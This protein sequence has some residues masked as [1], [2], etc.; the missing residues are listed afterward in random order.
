MGNSLTHFKIASFLFTL[1]A[2]ESISLPEYKGSALRGGFGYAFKKVV[3]ALRNRD[4]PECILKE[5]CVYS[6]VFETPPPADS[7]IM[8]KYPA[9]PHPF[10]L[11]PPL[12]E[13]RIYE[14]GEKI[15]FQ[16][17]LIGRAIDSLPYFIYTFEELGQ[18]GL[19]K[20][21]GKFKLEQ[22]EMSR[23]NSGEE[24]QRFIPIYRGEEKI[25]HKAALSP[26]TLCFAPPPLHPAPNAL[27]LL[28]LTPTR[29]KYEGDLASD[30][31]F[32]VFFRN[33]IRRISLLSYF[34]C[35][36]ELEVDFRGIIRDAE[37]IVTEQKNLRWYDWE[38]YSTR[39]DTRMKLGGIVGSI[40]FSGNL[41]PFW[42]YVLLGQLTHV[43]K[44]SSFGLGKYEI[45]KKD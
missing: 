35:S 9:A 23:I 11:C 10:V 4:C 28:F 37:H 29:L 44:G 25:L 6:Y 16:L 42:P 40:T 1:K 22:V 3:C 43:G 7:R 39:Q 19:G 17:T 26:A 21:R 13:D 18:M 20:G 41:D 5:K 32:H 8:R 24:D 30:F 27:R 12:E 33:L 14:A 2:S 38:R 34:H 45:L 31:Q 15:L 36:Q